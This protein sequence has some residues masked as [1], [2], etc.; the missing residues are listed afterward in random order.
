MT[1]N[2]GAVALSLA[3]TGVALL[4]A[5]QSP[6]ALSWQDHVEIQALY[7]TYTHSLDSG[8]ADRWA[9]TFTDAAAPAPLASVSEQ[10]GADA[11][12]P[13]SAEMRCQYPVYEGLLRL[14]FDVDQYPRH[15]LLRRGASAKLVL[16][17]E[18][19]QAVVLQPGLQPGRF[20]WGEFGGSFDAVG[21]HYLFRLEVV[22][23]E[24]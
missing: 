14:A 19:A 5:G 10:T 18:L 7:A 1:R 11:R 22:Q 13:D 16:L 9:E 6:P 4:G 24:G 23:Q 15:P 8:D 3:V 21:H 20:E 2:L 17:P 12:V